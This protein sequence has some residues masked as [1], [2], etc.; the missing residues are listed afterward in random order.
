[1]AAQLKSTPL[2]EVASSLER[3]AGETN[4]NASGLNSELTIGLHKE[5]SRDVDREAVKQGG[6]SQG[7]IVPIP[8]ATIRGPHPIRRCANYNL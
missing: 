7:L 6:G 3:H 5:H 4:F 8:H 1:M 2:I